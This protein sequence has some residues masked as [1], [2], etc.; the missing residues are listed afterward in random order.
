VSIK[1]LL[2]WLDC[3]KLFGFIKGAMQNFSHLK[4]LLIRTLKLYS[5]S[6]AFFQ[7]ENHLFARATSR[8][9]GAVATAESGLIRLECSV[10]RIDAAPPNPNRYH[11]C[12]LFVVIYDF[13]GTYN[14]YI[15]WTYFI[16]FWFTLLLTNKNV[17]KKIG[18][19]NHEWIFFTSI[20]MINTTINDC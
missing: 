13:F 1:C 6:I 19:S 7:N 8:L 12:L 5:Q 11:N 2:C 17:R 3:L 16:W 10:V 14:I 9:K 4:L 15:F 18:T 20:K